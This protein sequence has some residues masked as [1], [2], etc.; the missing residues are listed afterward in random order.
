MRLLKKSIDTNPPDWLVELTG[1]EITATILYNRGQKD[2]EKA[3]EYLFPEKYTPVQVGEFTGIEIALKLVQ[4]HINNNSNILIYGDYD[5]DGVSS[6]TI[7][8]ETLTQLN[9]NV[10]YHIPD[11]FKEG[12]GMNK[13]SIVKHADNVDLIITCDCGISNLEEVELAKKLGIEVI[14]TDHHDLPEQLPEAD[15]ILTP[16]FLAKD[17]PAYYL[18][19]AGMAY[20]FARA[21]LSHYQEEDFAK[22]LFDM[23]VLAVIADVVPLI[24]ENRYLFQIGID[25]LKNSDRPG[26]KALYKQLDLKRNDIDEK[27]IGFRLGPVINA[28]G[29]MEHASKAVDLFLA[30]KANKAASL[31]AEL[32]IINKERKKIGEKI[33][34]QITEQ[35]LEDVEE[36]IIL[37]KPDW[38][39]GIIGIIAGRL[40]EDYQLPVLLMTDQREGDLLT[41]SA[42]SPAGININLILKQVSNL[43]VKYGG[44]AAAAGFS[45]ERSQIAKFKE[46]VQAIIKNKQHQEQEK[47]IEADLE[48]DFKQ[49]D[50]N[51]YNNL[52]KLAPFGELNPEPIFYSPGVNV[53]YDR[54]I[55][56]GRH[57]KMIISNGK[58]KMKAIWWWGGQYE[59]SNKVSVAFQIDLNKYQGKEEIQL[60]IKG[61]EAREQIK[62]AK[63]KNKNFQ[64]D[65]LVNKLKLI[66]YRQQILE[67][68][69][70]NKPGYL[71]F[72]EG[73]G[74]T[75]HY[76]LV[77]RYYNR[78]GKRL[79]LLTNPPSLEILAETLLLSEVEELVLVNR[80]TRPVRVDI[81]LKKIL[82]T[83]KFAIL[84]KSGILHITEIAS[85]LGETEET[86]ITSLEFLK[87]AGKIN[88]NYLTY[89]EIFIEKIDQASSGK[90]QLKREELIGQLKESNAFRNYLVTRTMDE[91]KNLIITQ[92][93]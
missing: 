8:V 35:L 85:L 50:L 9:A 73:E 49:I 13:S 92:L 42:R 33:Y 31:A 60:I 36:V 84:K 2:R 43:L 51:L 7:L 69:P 82:G 65:S 77:N 4:K 27:T 62:H 26:L 38:H 70:V 19:G 54:L 37:Y 74:E 3:L 64:Q 32:V 57:R 52:R 58:K 21:L 45:L 55:S 1:D 71:Y 48:I 5:V 29:R 41:G 93:K 14:I 28:V 22:K 68:I 79:Y 66:D 89:Q 20:H 91:I 18:P 6:T 46:Q 39:Q 80:K 83:I 11:R 17:H 34:Q 61:V 25:Y 10:D 78:Q 47:L 72:F 40:V 30:K 56:G 24:G 86:I 16:K 88:F 81:F 75:K 59:L 87:L 15:V 53:E 12:Y 76:P 44:H 23:L 67:D 63:I 90:F